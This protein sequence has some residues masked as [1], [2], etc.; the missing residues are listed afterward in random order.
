MLQRYH[1]FKYLPNKN[2]NIFMSFPKKT[3]ICNDK[4]TDFYGFKYNQK[5]LQ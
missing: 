5:F 1:I 3:I 4:I 2:R